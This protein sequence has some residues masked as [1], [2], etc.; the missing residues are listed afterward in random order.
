ME[1]FDW[2]LV[3]GGVFCL[4]LPRLAPAIPEYAR[5]DAGN[6]QYEYLERVVC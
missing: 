1:A 3:G 4:Q 5:S 6:E 2:V